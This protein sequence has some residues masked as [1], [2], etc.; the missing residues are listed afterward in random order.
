MAKI[1]MSVVGIYKY[2][3]AKYTLDDRNYTDRYVQKALLSMLKEQGVHYDKIIFFLTKQA[4]E[5]NWEEYIREIKDGDDVKIVKDEGLLPF[6]QR[7]FPTVETVPVD[8]ASGENESELLDMY[9]TIYEQIGEKDEITFDITHGFRLMPLLFYPVMS[10]AK[11]LKH[12]T[13]EHIYYGMY[14][15]AKTSAPIVD[16]KQYDQILDWANATHN[17]VHFGNAGEIAKLMTEYKD[18]LSNEEKN[19]ASSSDKLA[20]A[21][22]IMTD[23]LLVCSGSK[24]QECRAYFNTRMNDDIR[25]NNASYFSLFNDLLEH[26]LKSLECFD[27]DLQP[28]EIG[29]NA[30]EWYMDKGLL[31]QAY[32]ALRESIIT[33]C[34]RVYVPEESKNYLKESYR[35][36]AVYRAIT[37]IVK[38]E[39]DKRAGKEEK[40]KKRH[41][42]NLQSIIKDEDIQK[43]MQKDMQKV[44]FKIMRHI[45]PEMAMFIQNL[46]N[47][48]N[49]IE[50]FAM[51]PSS[52]PAS[53]LRDR[54]ETYYK[55]TKAL[56][57][58]IESRLSEIP[59]DAQIEQELHK[60]LGGNRRNFI[61]FSNHPSERWSEEQK[62]AAQELAPDGVIVDVPFPQVAADA[63]E[64]EIEELAEEYLDTIEKQS[65]AAVMC[66]GE[67]GLCYAMI[68]RLKEKGIRVVY[69][70]TDRRAV[71]RITE[72]GVE[73][74]SIFQFVKFRNF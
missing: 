28:Y 56:F 2:D 23:E 26:A 24:I 61:N 37:A 36:K 55:K 30:V 40:A 63:D 68:R 32:T 15:D 43:D 39:Q 44:Y 35:E 53:K 11:E 51:K 57:A 14:K 6:L 50:H 45:N 20:K 29:M 17:F 22:N 65:P 3:V 18:A 72:N 13:V 71:E 62:Q 46:N 21:L 38:G 42:K 4:K 70:C 9:R 41:L 16:L 19:T 66:Q 49:Q 5:K 58:D 54:L 1:F 73:K 10:Y 69:S 25:K 33:Y 12:I 31:Q 48:R 60:L 47:D 8:I 52:V 27:G 34:C 7:E 59:T 64:A 74:V 67:F